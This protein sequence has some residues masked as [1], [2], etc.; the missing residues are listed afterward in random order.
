MHNGGEH[1]MFEIGR[2]Y[3]WLE[4]KSS[5]HLKAVLAFGDPLELTHEKALELAEVLEKLA[6]ELRQLEES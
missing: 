5:I 1:R 2:V 4:Q 3:L 6:A